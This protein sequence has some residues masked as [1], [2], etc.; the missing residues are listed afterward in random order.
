M[1]PELGVGTRGTRA[2]S[3]SGASVLRLFEY[4]ARTADGERLKGHATARDEVELDRML[5]RQGLTLAH[6]RATRR[7]ET[8]HQHRLGHAH[9][10]S[11]TTQLATLLEAGVPIVS[12][13]RQLEARTRGR[14]PKAVIA[15]ILRHLEA[16]LSLSEA[17]DEQPHSFPEVYRAAVRAGEHSMELPAVL[18]RQAKQLRWVRSLRASATQALVY[19]AILSVAVTGLVLVL[20]TFLLPR[21]ETL[22]PRDTVL[23]WQTRV[24]LCLSDVL[25]EHGLLIGGGVAL[26][27]VGWFVALRVRRTRVLL[28]RLLLAV[29][30]LGELLRM[31][32]TA[33][34]AS[35]ASDLHGAGCDAILTLTVAG[36]TCGAAALADAFERVTGRVRQGHGIADSLER[37]P[38]MDP[39]LVQL[40]AVGEASGDL[41]G[42]LGRLARCYDEEV[43][44]KVKWAM[45]FVEPLMLIVAACVVGF[46][47]LA[48]L[49]PILELYE[50]IG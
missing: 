38:L 4:T 13:L 50:S 20:L 33:R 7:R 16:G 34:F 39:L 37:E 26:A 49:L 29:P 6:A 10:V 17:L 46:I 41:D 5:E 40:V 30:R 43:P 27:L 42:C 25:V 31:I 23:P 11:F 48:A 44:T 1:P 22:F 15:M 19:P 36:E 8:V 45:S 3:A 21:L 47:L 2:G 18:S 24:V 14:A 28:S 9:L 12:G 32:A 35:T